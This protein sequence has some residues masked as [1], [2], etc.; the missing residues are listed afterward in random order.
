MK[1]K[2][3]RRL[4]SLT[5]E[6]MLYFTNLSHDV[7]YLYIKVMFSS[8]Q[9]LKVA[10]QALLDLL[11]MWPI[12]KKQTFLGIF[13]RFGHTKFLLCISFVIQINGQSYGTIN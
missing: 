9:L 13:F 5:D 11:C 7:Y 8:T 3:N 12:C 2:L 6:Y 4:Y 10:L 1:D